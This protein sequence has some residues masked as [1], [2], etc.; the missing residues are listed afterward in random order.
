MN[1]KYLTAATLILT[2]ITK[3]H[4]S[5]ASTP[6]ACASYP[7]ETDSS[8][9]APMTETPA[10]PPPTSAGELVISQVASFMLTERRALPIEPVMVTPQKHEAVMPALYPNQIAYASQKTIF[11]EL[12]A[13]LFARGAIIASYN[14]AIQL[15]VLASVYENV[16]FE[17][18]CARFIQLV[19]LYKDKPITTRNIQITIIT[20]QASLRDR[21]QSN[22]DS[23]GVRNFL[24]PAI[25]QVPSGGL[26]STMEWGL[27]GIDIITGRL[28]PYRL[29]ARDRIPIVL[30]P[31]GFLADKRT[32]YKLNP[33]KKPRSRASSIIKSLSRGS[34]PLPRLFRFKRK[35]D[36]RFA[37]TGQL[38]LDD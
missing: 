22:F 3:T 12:C 15:C 1:K 21:I 23:L 35:S 14:P 26:G 38:Q 11:K 27:Y 20:K 4:A 34:S 8:P 32:E 2:L 5:E 19:K 17:H 28:C 29:R 30:T 33:I 31:Q 18:L 16:E 10:P 25:T 9:E 13:S 37:S 36:I 6:L 24:S 7:H